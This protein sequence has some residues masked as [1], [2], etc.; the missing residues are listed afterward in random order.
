MS[1]N[2]LRLISTDL[3]TDR[4]DVL[5]RAVRILLL[6][7]SYFSRYYGHD[8]G[9][10]LDRVRSSLIVPLSARSIHLKQIRDRDR[11]RE[12]NL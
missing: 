1:Q 9:S 8:V 2:D 10:V 4:V 5:A 6:L 3:G 12:T 7:S 11:K